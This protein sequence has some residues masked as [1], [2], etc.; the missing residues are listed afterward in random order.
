MSLS[1]G[2][3]MLGL[4]ET[5]GEPKKGLGA[6]G[7]NERQVIIEKQYCGTEIL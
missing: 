5:L 6:V 3:H 1:H 4:L 7:L 2:T